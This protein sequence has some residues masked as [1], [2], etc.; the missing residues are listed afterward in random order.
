MHGSQAPPPQEKN[1]ICNPDDKIWTW[2]NF[3]LSY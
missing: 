1:P 2:T 3:N